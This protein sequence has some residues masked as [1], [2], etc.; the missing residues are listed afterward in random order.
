MSRRR[1]LS[2]IISVDSRVNRV[3]MEHGDWIALI[4]TWMIPH[5]GDDGYLRGDPDELLAQVL[6]LRRDLH[7]GH[8]RQALEILSAPDCGLIVW[9]EARRIV[10]FPAESFYRYQSYIKDGPRRG[11]R[12]TTPPAPG[13]P[14]PGQPVALICADPRES[15]A[16]GADLRDS[17]ASSAHNSADQRKSAQNSASFKSSSSVKSSVSLKSSLKQGVAPLEPAPPPDGDDDSQIDP[18]RTE[19]VIEPFADEGDDAATPDEEPRG[20]PRPRSLNKLQAARF[21]RFYAAYPKKTKRPAAERAWQ[22]LDPNEA[23]TVRIL[24]DLPA[25]LA[26]DRRWAEG[27]VDHPAT[28][29]NE[30]V[31]ED[32]MEPLRP[33]PATSGGTP[34]AARASP[35]DVLAQQPARTRRNVAILRGMGDEE[36]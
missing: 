19:P 8:M 36:E 15:A 30:R 29:L 26:G 22:R 31:W 6:P 5:A 27:F 21:E 32:D 25:R 17:A 9:D 12:D 33:V 35:D 23:L 3:A 28:Y 11:E 18:P 24:A 1:Y 13:Q 14:A 16:N 10:A 34:G 20:K 2:S 7:G 4:Y